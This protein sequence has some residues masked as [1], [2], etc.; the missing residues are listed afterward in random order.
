MKICLVST[1][2]LPNPGGVAAHVYGLARALGGLGHEVVVFTV[3][4]EGY[5]AGDRVEKGVRVVRASKGG[6]GRSELLLV[7]LSL[8][9]RVAARVPRSCWRLT[10]SRL[11][12]SLLRLHR[13][14]RFD[15]VHF[16]GLGTD[17]TL[18]KWAPGAATVFTNHTSMFLEALEQGKGPLLWEQIRH[19]DRFLAPSAQLAELT[20]AIGAAPER[21]ENIPNGVDTEEFQ[22]REGSAARGEWGFTP[23]QVLVLAARRLVKKNGMEYLL[24]AA[25]E[26]LATSPQA[27]L[28]IAGDGPEEEALIQLAATGGVADRVHFL[29]NI[30]RERLPDLVAMADIAVLPSL[31]EA[32]S[33][34]GLEAMA[35]GKPL[36][37]T[38]VGG[39]PEIIRD[40]ETGLLVPPADASALA[41]ALARLIRDEALRL[42]L[43]QAGRARAVAEF[44][45]PVIAARTAEAYA[46]AQEHAKSRGAGAY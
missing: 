46:R 11:G 9:R 3:A 21:V 4:R 10:E 43:G 28:V 29:G 45:W 24:Q 35:S 7:V 5:P 26:F 14:E 33:I 25:P 42:R 13:A 40:G 23:E 20:V 6:G 16:H 8:A 36:V 31:K 27:R 18:S 41:Q 37:G 15:L 34:A 39:I 19:A 44:A 17:A 2:Y 12:L 1:D 38:A 22:P 30:A 32:T